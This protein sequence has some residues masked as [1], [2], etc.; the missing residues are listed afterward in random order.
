[1]FNVVILREFDLLT[2]AAPFDQLTSGVPLVVHH[3][4]TTLILVH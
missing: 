2:A 1:M 4:L 3:H